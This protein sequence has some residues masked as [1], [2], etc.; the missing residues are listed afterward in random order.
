[1]TD[2]FDWLTA[3]DSGLAACRLADSFKLSQQEMR[4]TADAL[5]PAFTLALQRA[6]LDPAAW[7]RISHHFRPFWNA[8]GQADPALAQTPAARDLA[9]ALFGSGELAAA[10]SRHVSMASGVAPDTVDTLMR[11]LSILTMQTMVQTMIANAARNQPKG[12]AEGNYSAAMAEMMRRGANAME[13]L[14]RPSDTPDDR[15]PV[16]PPGSEYLSNLF[17]NALKG[18]MPWLPPTGATTAAQPAAEPTAPPTDPLA[19]FLPF[20]AMMGGFLRG[21]TP[22]EAPEAAADP[23]PDDGVLPSA[24]AD[25]SRAPEDGGNP[26]GSGT[27]LQDDYAQQMMAIF[28][29]YGGGDDRETG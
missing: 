13:A 9:A 25:L 22:P 10:V 27:Q 14:G 15:H 3:G 7:A 4:K 1:M 20:E 5:A 28:R 21:M 12:L 29:R 19:A 26:A 16:H 11:N 6:M 18:E 23:A 24:D 8:S 2:F 17:G